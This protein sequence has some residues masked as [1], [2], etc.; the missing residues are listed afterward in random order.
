MYATETHANAVRDADAE[1]RRCKRYGIGCC[2]LLLGYVVSLS[3][4]KSLVQLK[5]TSTTLKHLQQQ[6]KQQSGAANIK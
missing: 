1:R 4:C 2:V 6:Q 3:R 5:A